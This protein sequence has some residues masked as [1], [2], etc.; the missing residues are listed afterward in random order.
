MDYQGQS[1]TPLII[2]SKNGHNTVVKVLINKFKVNLEHEGCVRIEN[3]YIEGA[4]A[5][6]CAAGEHKILHIF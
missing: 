6:W 5:L 1:L 4:T 3:F 2:A